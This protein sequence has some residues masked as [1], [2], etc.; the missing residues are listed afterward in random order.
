MR[1]LAITL[2]IAVTLAFGAYV[3]LGVLNPVGSN[4]T[5]LEQWIEGT[6][7]DQD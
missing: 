6:Q 1:K 4:R 2:G 5:G 7:Y 3:A